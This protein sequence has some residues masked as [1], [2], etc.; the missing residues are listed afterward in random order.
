MDNVPHKSDKRKPY[1]AKTDK[2]AMLP[3][4]DRAITQVFVVGSDRRMHF[5]TVRSGRSRSTKVVDF[6]TNRKLVNSFLLVINSNTDPT[7][8]CLA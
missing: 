1:S 6:G 2:K 5:E 3:H 7:L 4:G 8:L